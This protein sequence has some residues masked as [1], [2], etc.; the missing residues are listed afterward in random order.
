MRYI[1]GIVTR[2]GMQGQNHR[3]YACKARLSP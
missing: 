1:D 2:L 3:G